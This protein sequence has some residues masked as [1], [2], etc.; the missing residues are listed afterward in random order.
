MHLFP[1]YLIFVGLLLGSSQS[2]ATAYRTM[3]KFL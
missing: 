3:C 1:N 2:H